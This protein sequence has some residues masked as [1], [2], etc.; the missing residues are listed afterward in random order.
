MPEPNRSQESRNCVGGGGD[1]M[2]VGRRPCPSPAG[3]GDRPDAAGHWVTRATYTRRRCQ[4]RCRIPSPNH[5]IKH[6]HTHTHTHTRYLHTPPPRAHTNVP[7]C[8]RAC[9]RSLP[10][11]PDRPAGL[12]PR[13]LPA[14]RTWA[15][16]FIM[17]GC[18]AK[19]VQASH[20]LLRDSA[21]PLE[22]GKDF[23][24]GALCYCV[25][26]CVCVCVCACVCVCVC[27]CVTLCVCVS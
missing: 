22:Y 23:K 20:A 1:A 17:E 12:L 11:G 6:T 5:A 13:W 14:A 19:I 27:Y 24:V 26:V 18:N 10:K 7:T 25:T 8:T 9:P 16:P 2:Y 15:G 3:Q 21:A 4:V